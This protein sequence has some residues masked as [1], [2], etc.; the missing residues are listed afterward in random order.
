MTFALFWLLACAGI[1]SDRSSGTSGCADDQC[2]LDSCVDGSSVEVMLA[3]CVSSHGRGL[4]GLGAETLA[5][6]CSGD[7]CDEGLYLSSAAAL[8]AAQAQGLAVGVSEC[9]ATF[10]PRDSSGANFNWDA[11]NV[12]RRACLDGEWSLGSGETVTVD[13]ISGEFLSSGYYAD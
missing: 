3:C 1:G 8:C 11:A 5:R 13:A 12:T 4:E 9:T 10:N 6:S 7:A 2:V